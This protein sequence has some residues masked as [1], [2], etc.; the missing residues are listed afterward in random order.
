[1]NRRQMFLACVGT[2]VASLF[3]GK[4]GVASA[5]TPLRVVNGLMSG[6]NGFSPRLGQEFH[7]TP[8]RTYEYAIT[9]NRPP[10]DFK[11]V[12]AVLRNDSWRESVFGVPPGFKCVRADYHFDATRT[13]LT[14]SR[15]LVGDAK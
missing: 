4:K 10:R 9:F 3:P 5:V 2:A 7:L 15:I 13:K 11:E 1:M 8:T 12:A 14:G 6:S